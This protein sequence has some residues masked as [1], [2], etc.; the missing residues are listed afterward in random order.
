ME[1]VFSVETAFGLSYIVLEGDSGISK[2]RVLPSY[3]FVPTSE[4]G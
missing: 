3:E 2:I 4:F 1:L